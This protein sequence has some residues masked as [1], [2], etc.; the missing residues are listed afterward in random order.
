MDSQQIARRAPTSLL[1]AAGLIA[2]FGV[3][4]GS[5]SRPLGGVVIAIFGLTCIWLWLQRDGRRTAVKLTGV[6]LFAF[7]FSHVLGLVI[8]AW[9][10]VFVVS[11]ATA[12]A[13]WRLSDVKWLGR[14]A[15][16]AVTGA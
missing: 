10:S 13:C 1:S 9:P 5:G 2:G 15:A 12:Y 3:A 7:A 8:G 4:V 11:A 6:G 14:R 16:A